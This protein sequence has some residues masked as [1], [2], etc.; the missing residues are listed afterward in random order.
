MKKAGQNGTNW[1]RF[2]LLL[3]S[4]NVPKESCRACHE[5]KNG[6]EFFFEKIQKKFHQYRI[7]WNKF[8]LLL[9]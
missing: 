7:K 9:Q 1:N 5:S 4:K 6:H 3:Q 2:E 8:E